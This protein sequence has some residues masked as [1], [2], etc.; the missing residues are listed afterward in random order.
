VVVRDGPVLLEPGIERGIWLPVR[1]RGTRLRPRLSD[2]ATRCRR[3]S[4]E[5]PVSVRRARALP[6]RER[7]RRRSWP[8]P[9]PGP[10]GRRELRRRKARGCRRSG[11]GARRRSAR[12]IRARRALRPRSAGKLSGR[13]D[14][15][16]RSRSPIVARGPPRDGG[17]AR[18][19]RRWRQVGAHAS[20]I[21][22]LRPQWNRYWSASV[23]VVAHHDVGSCRRNR[24]TR[25][26]PCRVRREM[27]SRPHGARRRRR[28]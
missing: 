2:G 28:Q 7:I 22:T 9:W 11:H 20:S 4:P 6:S 27:H 1:K 24:V 17:G 19:S 12:D 8:W 21:R 18:G 5:S 15:T 13:V 25:K 23:E 14:V 26:R 3:R 10:R 16:I